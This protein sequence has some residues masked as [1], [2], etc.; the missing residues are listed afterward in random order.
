MIL[1]YY[2]L[3]D[4]DLFLSGLEDFIYKMGILVTEFLI[5]M[6]LID[7]FVFRMNFFC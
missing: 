4:V 2:F 3:K 1:R 5:I 6:N 7:F